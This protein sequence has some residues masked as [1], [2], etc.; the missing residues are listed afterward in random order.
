MQVSQPVLE[1]LSA[2]VVSGTSLKLIGQLDRKLYADTN[3]V[4]EAAGGK[5]NKKAGAHVFEGMAIDTIEPILMTGTYS[6]TKQDFGQFDSTPVVVDRVI[7]LADIEPGMSVLEPSAGIGRIASAAA[8]SGGV[9]MAIE[10]DK[11]R[12]AK[13]ETVAE[14]YRGMSVIQTDFL[15]LDPLICESYDR[16]TMNPP[17]AK[18]ADIEHVN[19]AFKFLKQGGRLVSVMSAGVGYRQDRKAVEFRAF[20]EERGGTIERLPDSA[21]KDS[22]TNV[23]TVI[24]VIDN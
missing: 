11:T 4:I 20:V 5:W 21:F 22:G 8:E 7:E 17:F 6:R 16:I 3:K 2:A 9:V 18:Q 14:A 15:T 13:L 12:V 23:S 1:V 10:I 19:H 24:V